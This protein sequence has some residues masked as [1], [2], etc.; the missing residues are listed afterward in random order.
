MKIQNVLL[1]ALAA[2]ARA[3]EKQVQ[4]YFLHIETPR[5]GVHHSDGEFACGPFGKLISDLFSRTEP[6]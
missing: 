2:D 6:Y 1:M 5:T 3:P 4:H